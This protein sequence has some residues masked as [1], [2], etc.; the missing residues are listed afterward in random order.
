[1]RMLTADEAMRLAR[2]LF[3]AAGATEANAQTVADHLV[4]CSLMGLHSHGLM[5]VGQYL[6]EIASGEI[7]PVAIPEVEFRNRAFVRLDGW[8]AFGQVGGTAAVEEASRLA[9][10]YG[11]AAAVVRRTGHAG[12]IGAYVQALAERG[13]VGVAFCSG[14][15][16]G[17]WVAPFGGVEGRTATN[18]IAYGLPA[19]PLPIVADF[20][21]S[22]IPE[23][24]VRVLRDRGIEAPPGVLQD[25]TGA[26]ST[27]PNVLYA[28]PPGTILPL[29]GERFGY[30][31]TALALL[32]EAIATLLAGDDIDDQDR[33]GNNLAVFALASDSSFA[34][35]AT[36]MADYVRSSRPAD[37][38][39]PV[40]TPGDPEQ[41][42]RR[43]AQGVSVDEAMWQSLTALAKRHGI[44]PPRVTRVVDA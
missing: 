17:H 41:L 32:V 5:R 14:P 40:M 35:R 31:G 19:D 12:R 36:R 25:A 2:S 16:S 28:D 3:L 33:F 4:E 13:F 27:N 38:S 7:N 9:A 37:A 18:P 10:V 39:R 44:A 11:V 15:V 1:M 24:V 21:S 6:E 43:A 8:R 22:T 23:G 26:P 30:K 29:G 20:S 42:S 34:A